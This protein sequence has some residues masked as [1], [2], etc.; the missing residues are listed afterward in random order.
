[1][2]VFVPSSSEPTLQACPLLTDSTLVECSRQH[3]LDRNNNKR[4]QV[5]RTEKCIGQFLID[6]MIFENGV[7]RHG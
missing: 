5:D 4:M 7:Y 1:M 6:S 2:V 3:G